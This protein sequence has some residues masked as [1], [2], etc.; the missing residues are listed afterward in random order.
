MSRDQ[1]IMSSQPSANFEGAA[2]SANDQYLEEPLATRVRADLKKHYFA[3]Q[4]GAYG[5]DLK[6][7]WSSDVWMSAITSLTPEISN[8]RTLQIMC[9]RPT[10]FYWA[11][12]AQDP[13]TGACTRMVFADVYK[14]WFRC[15]DNLPDIRYDRFFAFPFRITSAGPQTIRE[16]LQAHAYMCDRAFSRM[17]SIRSGEVSSIICQGKHWRRFNLLPLCRAIV[18]LYDERL[19]HPERE[20]DGYL[21]L[22]KDVDRRTAVLILTGHNSGLSAPVDF[23]SIRSSA[24]PIA[25]DDADTIDASSVIR[26]SLK[27]AVQFITKLQ[28]REES[29]SSSPKPVELDNLDEPRKRILWEDVDNADEYAEAVLDRPHESRDKQLVLNYVLERIEMEKRGEVVLPET[30]IGHHWPGS[31]V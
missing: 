29:A 7:L 14:A 15:H 6:Y 27:T 24:L 25:R 5:A 20:S 9:N 12:S 3:V 26:V 11:M 28:Q 4:E 31:W 2:L 8:D 23:D 22:D 1:D 13:E 21:S 19:D 17:E 30:V 16:L 18:V 10:F